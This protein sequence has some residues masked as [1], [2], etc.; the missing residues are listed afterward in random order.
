MNILLYSPDNGVTKNFMPHLWMFLLKALTPPEH[1]VYLI[2]GNAQPMTE[3]AI[4]EFVREK[5]IQLAGIS[6]MTR[7]AA[8]AYRM[9]DAIRGA[10]AKVVFG[11]P[12]VTEVPDEPLGR[13]GEPRHAD[14]IALG[15]ADY[16][17]P[18]IVADAAAGNLQEIYKPVDEHGA[19]VKP[20]LTDYPIIPWEALDLKQFN[21]MHKIPGPVRSI[22]RGFT[23]KWESLY[24]IPIESGRG[25]P[26]GCDFC[27]VTGF[28]GDSIRFRTNQSVVDELLSIKR[29]SAAEHGHVAVFFID[30]NFAINVKRTKSLLRDIIAQGA[31]LPWVA[32]ISINLLKDEELLDLIKASGGRWIFIGLESVDSENLAAV[33]KGFN[34]PKDYKLALDRLADRGIYAITSFI[35]GMDGETAGVAKRTHDVMETWPPGLPVYGLMTPYPATPLYDRLLQAGRLTRPKHWLDFRPFRMAYTPDNIT[36]DQAEAEVREAWARSYSPKAIADGLQRIRKRP[37]RERSVMFV[38]RLAFRG[39]YFPQMKRKDWVALIWSNRQTL[40]SLCQEALISLWK[41]SRNKRTLKQ[42]KLAT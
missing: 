34:K 35:F 21:M 11:G 15:E 22:L 3:A 42:E 1:E 4:A 23:K 33:N 26:Y 2:D 30:D 6:A 13:S 25:C 41:D 36:V 37:F 17:W 8:R 28:F 24:M 20:S 29:R 5:N 39:I 19:E 38:A 32:Q 10:G 40:R 7:M 9:A 16:T 14:A 27:T 31:T 18:R 12:H